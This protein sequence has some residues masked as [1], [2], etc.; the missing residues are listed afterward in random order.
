MLMLIMMVME[1]IVRTLLQLLR[2]LDYFDISP[3]E[4]CGLLLAL[5]F[6]S[7]VMDEVSKWF[8]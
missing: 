4:L 7:V 6:H 1:M 3:L 2:R 5:L 8:V